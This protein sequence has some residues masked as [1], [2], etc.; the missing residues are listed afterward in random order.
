MQIQW[1]Q[2]KNS[3]CWLLT[4]RNTC[5]FSDARRNNP[6]VTTNFSNACKLSDARRK[7]PCVTTSLVM[8]DE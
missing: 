6:G 8:W 1:C 2:K 5:K 7:I 4:F 3:W